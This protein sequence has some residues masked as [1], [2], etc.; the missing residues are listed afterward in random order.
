MVCAT[1]SRQEETTGGPQR[2][3]ISQVGLGFLY[4]GS[5]FE[6]VD[7]L[8][9]LL[10]EI[11][12]I[13]SGVNTPVAVRTERG[14]PSRMIRSFIREA[15]D[16]VRLQIRPSPLVLKR[17]RPL[18]TFAKPARSFERISLNRLATLIDSPPPLLHRNPLASLF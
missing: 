12:P 10:I 14:N 13:R 16:M 6:L 15:S 4:G 8:S 3:S 1:P 2:E 7:L 9:D 17:S 18:T 11:A 5:L